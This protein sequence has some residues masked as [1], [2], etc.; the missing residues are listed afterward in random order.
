MLVSCKSHKAGAI[1]ERGENPVKRREEKRRDITSM[2][3]S[4]Y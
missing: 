1:G 2:C 3:S 4:L